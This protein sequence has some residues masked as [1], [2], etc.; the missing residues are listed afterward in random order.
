MNKVVKNG[1]GCGLLSVLFIVAVVALP[2]DIT[3]PILAWAIVLSIPLGIANAIMWRFFS[4][5]GWWIWSFMWIAAIAFIA[6]GILFP[7]FGMR[8]GITTL[9]LPEWICAALIPLVTL[10]VYELYKKI[11]NK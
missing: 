3:V 1:I 9:D 5:Y 10:C 2:E 7:S 11:K 8:F 4:S 6:I